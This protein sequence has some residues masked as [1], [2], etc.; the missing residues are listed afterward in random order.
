MWLNIRKDKDKVKDKVEEKAVI[1][2]AQSSNSKISKL[3]N[4]FMD[5]SDDEKLDDL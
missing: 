2:N 1:P 4:K 3:I 5:S